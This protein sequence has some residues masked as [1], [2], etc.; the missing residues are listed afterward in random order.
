MRAR[1]LLPTQP[2][3]A[4]GALPSRE[5]VEVIQRIVSALATA[6]GGVMASGAFLIDDG[7]ASTDGGFS[8]DDGGAA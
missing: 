6:G 5:M 7:T 1:P 3:T 8:L 4:A 2:V